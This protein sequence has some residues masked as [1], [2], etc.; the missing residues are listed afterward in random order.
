MGM[1]RFIILICIVVCLLFVSSALAHASEVVLEGNVSAGDKDS[2]AYQV[3]V[4][5]QFDPLYENELFDLTPSLGLSGHAWVPDHGN[6]IWGATVPLGLRFRMFTSAGFRPYLS[7]AV[8]PTFLSDDK[9]D[10]RDL[11]SHVLIMS[12]GALGVNF[13]D[14]LQHRVEGAYTYYSTWGITNTD[15]G[16]DTWGVSYGYSF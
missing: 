7:G 13:G 1:K 10:N 15:P 4:R 6:T 9:L 11:G 12:R 5:Q 16:Y 8:G 3:G 2:M 14:S